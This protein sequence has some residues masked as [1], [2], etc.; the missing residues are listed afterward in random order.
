MFNSFHSAFYTFRLK[1][2]TENQRIDSSIQLF[3]RH[4]QLN[5]WELALQF[6]LIF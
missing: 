5:I 2:K 3:I 6:F 1:I 4:S